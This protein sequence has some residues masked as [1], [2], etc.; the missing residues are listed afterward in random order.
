MNVNELF[1]RLSF[2]ELSN[3]SIGSEGAGSINE[4]GRAKII[5]YANEG[6]LRLYSRYVLKE[7]NL[8]LQL[9]DFITN[10]HLTARY[11][12]SNANPLQGDT[13]YIVD[14]LLEP[15]PDDVIKVLEVTNAIGQRLPLNDIDNALSL[16]TPQPTMLQ[17]TYPQ[18]G[19]VLSVVYQAQHDQLAYDDFDARIHLPRVLE[20]ALT[21]FVA[22]KVFLHMNGQDNSAKSAEHLAIFEGICQDV[23]DKD[24]VNSSSSSSGAKFHDRGFV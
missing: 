10:Y 6:L 9:S 17:M 7:S 12:Q 14:N 23:V 20:G 3:L 24:L 13:L 15:F 1:R 21:A 16:F 4:D 5:S 2:G 11:A 19:Q 8:L 18:E 22:H